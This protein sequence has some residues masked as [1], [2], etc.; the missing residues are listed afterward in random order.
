[1]E[2]EEHTLPESYYEWLNDIDEQVKRTVYRTTPIP[3]RAARH[4]PAQVD[5]TAEEEA[6]CDSSLVGRTAKGG[7][8]SGQ[9]RPS[10]SSSPLG[11]WTGWKMEKALAGS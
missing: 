8:I 6:S 4:M 3:A 2:L 11:G 10:R 9:P 1:L 7:P 5:G